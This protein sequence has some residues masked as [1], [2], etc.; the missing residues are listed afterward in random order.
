MTAAKLTLK[1]VRARPVLLPLKRPIVSRVGLFREWPL[2]LI[3]L[4]NERGHR[5]PQLPRAVPEAVGPLPRAADRGSGAARRGL[6]VAPI[7]QYRS[8]IGSVQLV[9]REGLTLIAVSGLDMAAWDALAQAAGQ[10]LAEYLGGTTGPVPAYNSNGL[11]LSPLES[12]AAEAD[13]LIREGGFSARGR[14]IHGGP[15]PRGTPVERRVPHSPPLGEPALTARPSAA[16]IRRHSSTAPK[17]VPMTSNT[18]QDRP[19]RHTRRRHRARAGHRHGR[20]RRHHRL[21]RQGRRA[22]R[23]GQA[24]HAAGGPR[25]GDRADRRLRRR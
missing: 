16:G 6:P 10:P 5:R 20:G 17:D 21:E 9:G 14:L 2:I 23:R 8:A 13:A 7:D 24:R 1:G 18:R 12:I 25:D 22:D 11:W 4:G 15:P 3:D 19:L